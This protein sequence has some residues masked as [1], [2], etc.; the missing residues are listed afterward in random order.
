MATFPSNLCLKS[1]KVEYIDNSIKSEMDGG[2]VTIR[3]RYTRKRRRFTL[4]LAPTPLSDI[5]ALDLFYQT[6]GTYYSFSFIHP[7]T[8]ENV[9]CVF[10]SPLTLEYGTSKVVGKEIAGPIILEEV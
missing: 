4:T 8:D 7:K 5:E 3:P 1:L 9:Q 6:Y 10:G 2:S